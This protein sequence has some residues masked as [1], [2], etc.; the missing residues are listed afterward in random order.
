[1]TDTETSSLS[2]DIQ[3]EKTRSMFADLAL[4]LVKEKPL[5]VLGGVIVL[6]A[7]FVGIFANTLAPYGMN[8][9]HPADAL[10]PPSLK[11]PMGTD[12]LGR[13]L[14]SRVMLG[15]RISMIVGLGVPAISVVVS[16]LLGCTSG[17]IGGKFDL[18]LQRFVDAWIAFPAL[19][20]YLTILGITGAGLLPVLLVLG[21]SGGI[22]GSRT[23]RSAVIAIKENAYITAAETI[24]CT[25]GR[26]LWRHVLPNIMP[27]VI[28]L[29]TTRMAGAILAE[30]AISFL[31]F[32]VPPPEPSW[33]GMLSGGGRRFMSYA[34]WMALFP[35]IALSVVVYGVSMFGDG[36]RDIL[37]PR[38]RGGK[39]SYETADKKK[40][41]LAIF[42]KIKSLLFNTA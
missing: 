39:G 35:G 5:S 3:Q 29:F 7:L 15:A 28:I 24:G 26:M 16:L 33:G 11:Y 40:I 36:V 25:L 14:L 18:I 38:L 19:I 21:I 13:D 12:N 4:R 42:G 17:Y 37:D 1:M 34:P 32:G 20:I 27:I 8:E 31:G 9:I 6:I 22:G 30:A 23:M 2:S 10:S 41:R